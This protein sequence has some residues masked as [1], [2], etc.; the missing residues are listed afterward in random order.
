MPASLQGQVFYQP[1]KQGFESEIG[2][3]VAR[4]REAQLAALVEGVGVAPAEILTYGPT[5]RTYERWMQRTLGQVG[6]QLAQQRDRLFTLAQPQRHHLVLDINAGSG[7]LTQ[8][9]LRRVPE[10]GVYAIVRTPED[11]NALQEQFSALPELIRPI[12]LSATWSEL[13]TVLANHSPNVL[14]DR[15]I[16]RNA[17]V[18]QTDKV[19]TVRHLAKLLLQTG[20]LVLAETVPRHM[21]RLYGLL[22][23][24]RLND[25]LYERLVAAEEAIYASASDPMVNWDAD[26][27]RLV[28]EAA[29]LEVKVTTERTS[30]QMYITPALLERWFAPTVG[31]AKERPTYAQH[32]AHSLMAE[33]VCTVQDLFTSSLLHQTVTW[34]STIAYMVAT[35]QH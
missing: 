12:V 34:S 7:L 32:L 33:E 15:I 18:H 17:L 19:A 35:K 25:D 27:L 1:S 14:F 5:D 6:E 8:E 22:D 28:I 9:A 20:V 26:E 21:Q 31:T 2:T 13:P 24:T 16:G 3:Q 10:G 30:T 4:Q 29:G 23:P 11:S